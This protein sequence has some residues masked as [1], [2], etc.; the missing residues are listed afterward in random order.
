MALSVFSRDFDDLRRLVEEWV[1]GNPRL[2]GPEP[3]ELS[4]IGTGSKCLRK[5]SGKLPG[6][7]CCGIQ[8]CKYL[9]QDWASYFGFDFACLGICS[10]TNC[11]QWLWM[12]ISPLFD[13]PTRSESLICLRRL[14]RGLVADDAAWDWEM[15]HIS[16]RIGVLLLFLF[17]LFLLLLLPLHESIYLGSCLKFINSSYL[18]IQA[19]LLLLHTLNHTETGIFVTLSKP[20]SLPFSLQTC[21]RSPITFIFCVR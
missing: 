13:R 17:L 12:S 16:S 8:R 15:R 2:F 21:T 3:P 20:P 19:L 9:P 10:T 6:E 1:R 4:K 11:R 5:T 7:L 14:G 18:K